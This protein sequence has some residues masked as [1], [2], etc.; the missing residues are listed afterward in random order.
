MPTAK[1]GGHELTVRASLPSKRIGPLPIDV[2]EAG[3]GHYVAPAAQLA[4]AGDW[5]LAGLAT[6]RRRSAAT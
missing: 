4:P 6:A 2:R 1:G 3:P 5:R